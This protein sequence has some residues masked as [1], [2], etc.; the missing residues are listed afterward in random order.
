MTYDDA[1]TC[2]AQLIMAESRVLR[3]E[4]GRL[5][6]ER[7]RAR[8]LMQVLMFE[9]ASLSAEARSVREEMIYRRSVSRRGFLYPPFCA[10][11]F[12]VGSNG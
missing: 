2:R 12:E 3:S 8:E 5:R 6:A 10:Q 1:L 11:L 9:N 4:L 7:Q